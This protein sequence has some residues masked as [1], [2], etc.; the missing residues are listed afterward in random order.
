MAS[1]KSEPERPAVSY[2]G[3]QVSVNIPLVHGVDL[4]VLLKAVQAGVDQ[5]AANSR[6]VEQQQQSWLM[7]TQRVQHWQLRR[8]TGG[9]A[10]TVG[11]QPPSSDDSRSSMQQLSVQVVVP[12]QES[13]PHEASDSGSSGSRHGSNGSRRGNSGG[14]SESDVGGA[15]HVQVAKAAPFTADELELLGKLVAAANKPGSGQVSCCCCCWCVVSRHVA[16]QLQL[17]GAAGCCCKQARVGPGE[18]LLLLVRFVQVFELCVVSRHVARWLE[19]LAKLVA[20]ANK[21]GSG[22]VSCC[23]CWC[24]LCKR[25]SWV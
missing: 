21:P 13:S 23:C 3:H 9:K 15:G 11:P 4:P 16:K 1:H 17:W 5:L 20:A 14:S 7:S 18:L 12:L 10:D 8:L 19:L 25:L 24:G 2:D 22:Q 6:R